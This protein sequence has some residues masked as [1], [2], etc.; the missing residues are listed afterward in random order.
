[1]PTS[2]VKITKAT[3]AELK[4]LF[5]SKPE[6]QHMAPHVAGGVEAFDYAF[7]ALEAACDI[8]P[9]KGIELGAVEVR[10]IDPNDEKA[11]GEI[12]VTEWLINCVLIQ[13]DES[14][15]VE[16]EKEVSK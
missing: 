11:M 5:E 3:L 2:R 9:P 8:T 1:M 13:L 4:G 12:A 16:Q 7:R 6:L 10:A 14:K 15:K